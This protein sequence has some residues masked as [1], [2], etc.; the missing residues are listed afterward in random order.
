MF[1]RR[2]FK[3]VPDDSAP[4]AILADESAIELLNDPAYTGATVSGLE[5][6][7][8]GLTPRHILMRTAA[9]NTKDV[10]I[11]SRIQYDLLNI[12][13]AYAEPAFGEVAAVTPWVIT[14]KYPERFRGRPVNLDTGMVDGDNP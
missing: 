2:Y 14:T 5:R 13:D 10:I 8:I 11:L 3:Y 9:G 12:G 7:P 6:R 1:S 4:I